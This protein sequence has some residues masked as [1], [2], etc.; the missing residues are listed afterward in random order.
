MHDLVRSLLDRDVYLDGKRYVVRSPTVREALTLLAASEGALAGES[1]QVKVFF[2]VLRG[3]LPIGLFTL[4]NASDYPVR[5]VV[6]FVFQA[7]NEGVPEFAIDKS[8]ASDQQEET[9]D[10]KELHWENIVA[11]YMATYGVSLKQALDEP[12][13][14][15]LL[16][17]RKADMIHARDMLRS[18]TARGVPYIKSDRDREKTIDDLVKR[19]GGEVMTEEE[20]HQQRL[21][22][23]QAQLDKVARQFASVGAF[24]GKKGEA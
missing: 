17:S 15:F 18:M 14:G 22:K 11:E 8:S 1:T 24:V 12:W 5:R 13:N 10:P 23:Q 16:L 4:F 2:D 9:S 21:A 3:W 20:R 19:A 6:A 7:I